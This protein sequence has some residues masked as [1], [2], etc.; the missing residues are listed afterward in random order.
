M[1]NDVKL[2]LLDLDGTLCDE[3]SQIPSSFFE[4]VP[5]L[6]KKGVAVGIASGRN[7]ES[8]KHA[9]GDLFNQMACVTTNG[10]VNYIDGEIIS[11]CYLDKDVVK[12]L[13]DKSK[14][15]DGC[16]IQ[17]FYP[18]VIL[19]DKGNPLTKFMNEAGFAAKECDNLYDHM[20]DVV[21]ISTIAMDMKTDFAEEFSN[22]G[23][24]YKLAQ[25]GYGCIDYMPDYCS[26]AYGARM[27][28]NHLK[29]TMDQVMAIGDAGN[30]IELLQAVGHPVA[31][32]NAMKECKELARYVTEK[33]NIEHGCIDFL[34]KFFK[35]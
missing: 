29:I 34:E 19:M 4:L 24:P 26:K 16:S 22:L 32:K 11:T 31:M 21:L 5:K 14:E 13:L 20:D 33:T 30:D 7:G 23:G 2:V 3:N 9:C 28:A 10:T 17:L 18:E 12:K 35:V 15:V 6:R 8:I 25:S 27:L 1:Y